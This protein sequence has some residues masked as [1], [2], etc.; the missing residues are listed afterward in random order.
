MRLFK[1]VKPGYKVCGFSADKISMLGVLKSLAGQL[2]NAK[3]E[4]FKVPDTARRVDSS[5]YV[6][7]AIHPA[8]FS[9]QL[10]RMQISLQSEQAPAVV[11]VA[12]K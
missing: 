10:A 11:P 1:I 3:Q 9:Q 7:M 5:W 6:G 4:M 12:R 8:E 2:Q